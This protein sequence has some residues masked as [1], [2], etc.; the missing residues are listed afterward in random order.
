MNFVPNCNK[1]FYSI[2]IIILAGW[3]AGWLAGCVLLSVH[4]IIMFITKTSPIAKQ[5]GLVSRRTTLNVM[6]GK[7]IVA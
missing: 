1:A 2:Y 5:P 3:L 7:T 6:T 4:L